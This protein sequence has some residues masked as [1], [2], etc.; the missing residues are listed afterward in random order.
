VLA[1]YDP[2][3]GRLRLHAPL[4]DGDEIAVRHE[5]GRILAGPAGRERP[6]GGATVANTVA[7][8]VTMERPV[9][10]RLASGG[11]W[12]GIDVTVR[13]PGGIAVPAAAA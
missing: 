10:V 3:T 5:R 11:G 7:I 9:R 2:H 13:F 12:S 8:E 1:S 4:G 6:C